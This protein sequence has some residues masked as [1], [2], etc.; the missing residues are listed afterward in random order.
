MLCGRLRFTATLFSA[1]HCQ[2]GTAAA[3]R[4]QRFYERLQAG[5]DPE[6]RL[7]LAAVHVGPEKLPPTAFEVPMREK[8]LQSA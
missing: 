8:V 4:R 7:A 2:F 5:D 3:A 6:L 1:L